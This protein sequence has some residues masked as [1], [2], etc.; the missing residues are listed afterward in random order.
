MSS[1]TRYLDNVLK[2]WF[3]FGCGFGFTFHK[4][5]LIKPM[6]YLAKAF[7]KCDVYQTVIEFVL[8]FVFEENYANL[9]LSIKSHWQDTF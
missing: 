4:G 7:S 1:F 6:R 8:N 2:A 9:M 5:S 3:Q